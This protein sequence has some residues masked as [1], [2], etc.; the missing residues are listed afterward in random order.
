MRRQVQE[1]LGVEP[2]E[3]P[4]GHYV[5]LSHPDVVAA[6]LNEFAD[7]TAMESSQ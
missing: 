7:R 2:V 6:V 3:I 1:R 4:G 5:T